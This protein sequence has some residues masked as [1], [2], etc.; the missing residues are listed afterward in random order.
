M[1]NA[2]FDIHRILK[3]ILIDPVC[4]R[5]IHTVKAAGASSIS[6]SRTGYAGP[7]GNAVTAAANA[8][9]SANIDWGYIIRRFIDTI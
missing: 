1:P 3:E 5:L 6:S 7:V 9:T 4:P 2:I 8:R